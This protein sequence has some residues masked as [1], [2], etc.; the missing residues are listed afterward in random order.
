MGRALEVIS[1]FVTNN[2]AL[3][4]VTAVTGDSFTVRSFRFESGA[5]LENAWGRSVADAVLRIRSPRMHD[6]VEGIRL[7]IEAATTQ[8][9]LADEVEQRLF[10]Q[11]PLTVQTQSGAADTTA[12]SLLVYY[13][14]LPGIDAN[15]ADWE[16]VKGRLEHVLAVE[17]TDLAAP[18]TAGQFGAA[19]SIVADF[20]QLKANTDYA[21]LGYV[22]NAAA[23]TLRITGSDFGNLG[24]GGPLT[25]DTAFTR[26][27]FIDLARK[28]G[29][30]HI[31]VFNAAN[32]DNVLV[33]QSN[34]AASGTPDV[35]IV[36]AQLRTG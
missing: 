32:K 6:Q 17:Q 13:E 26:G 11:D 27:W 25:P 36:L 24:V 29:R 20:D 1:G 18:G 31:P 7:Q 28:S 8:Q 3:T 15:L 9:L 2:T 22:T 34:N 33:D 35:S 12:V 30:P 21:V 23:G 14:D 16:T 19:Q 4:T 5:F 10:P